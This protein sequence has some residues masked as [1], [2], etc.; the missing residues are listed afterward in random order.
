M[1]SDGEKGESLTL[2][3]EKGGMREEGARVSEKQETSTVRQ[4]E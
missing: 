3:G 1:N 2:Q 4:R